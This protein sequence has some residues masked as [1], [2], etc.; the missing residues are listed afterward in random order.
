[1][2]DQDGNLTNSPGISLPVHLQRLTSVRKYF[3]DAVLD[4]TDDEFQ[5][6]RL[7]PDYKVTPQWVIYHL[8]QHE[9]EHWGQIMTIREAGSTS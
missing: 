1:V 4:I 7:F 5:R 3:M 6:V 2:R 9:A 8:M